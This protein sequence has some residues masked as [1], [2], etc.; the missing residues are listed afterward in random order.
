MVDFF[1]HRHVLG[2]VS[3][4][5]VRLF[6]LKRGLFVEEVPLPKPIVIEGGLKRKFFPAKSGPTN[7]GLWR[8]GGLGFPAVSI[9]VW[10]ADGLWILQY[11]KITKQ[12]EF[13]V[14]VRS[15]AIRN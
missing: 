1:A 4:T 9:G 12:A 7:G 3:A 11:P 6:D 14:K 15:T 13:L 8:P 10:G 2:V 5:A